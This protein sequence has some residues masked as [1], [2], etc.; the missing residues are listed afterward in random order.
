[1]KYD[2][3]INQAEA[4]AL[5]LAMMTKNGQLAFK[6]IS[7]CLRRFAVENGVPRLEEDG[8]TGLFNKIMRLPIDRRDALAGAYAILLEAQR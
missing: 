7:E 5:A 8:D 4:Q 2:N 6:V 1:V 3:F